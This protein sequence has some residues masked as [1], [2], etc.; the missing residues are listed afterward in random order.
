MNNANHIRNT[1]ETIV[2]RVVIE[3]LKTKTKTKL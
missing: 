1:T 2:R 3:W